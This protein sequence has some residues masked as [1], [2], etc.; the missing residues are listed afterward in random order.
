MIT[1]ITAQ[2]NSIT[3]RRNCGSDL[4]L[5]N[6]NSLS[7]QEISGDPSPPAKGF[8]QSRTCMSDAWD[9]R[10]VR[11]LEGVA[12]ERKENSEGTCEKCQSGLFWSTKYG[13]PTYIKEV[14]SQESCKS[15][16]E[17]RDE[18]SSEDIVDEEKRG[19]TPNVIIEKNGMYFVR[20]YRSNNIYG[21]YEDKEDA[22]HKISFLDYF[23]QSEEEK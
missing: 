23:R 10:K 16:W 21:P 5:L 14:A 17:V 9:V 7:L 4:G 1:L 12:V 6:R 22:E 19:S 8:C 3:K 13:P 18:I 15:F 2:P 20:N 11:H